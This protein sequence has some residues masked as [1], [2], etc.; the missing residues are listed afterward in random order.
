[1]KHFESD[2]IKLEMDED[3]L[4]VFYKKPSLI[5][6]ETAKLDVEDRLRLQNG[7]SHYVITDI[8]NLKSATK[9]AREFLSNPDG[10]L[11]GIIAGAFISGSVFSYAILNLFLKINKPLIPSRFFS[12]KSDALIWINQLKKNKE[13]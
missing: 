1:M 9:E 6:L 12:S 7:R 11:K 8:A 13:L 2:R 5:D 10:G 4:Y 3:I